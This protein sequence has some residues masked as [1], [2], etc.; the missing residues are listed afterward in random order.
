MA[1]AVSTWFKGLSEGWRTFT[2]L[3]GF[4]V[5]V[6][7]TAVAIDHFKTKVSDASSVLKYLQKQDTVQTKRFNVINLHLK[8]ISDSLRVEYQ[9]QGVFQE[10]YSKFV[11]SKTGS[12]QEWMKYMNGMQVT[13]VQDYYIPNKSY[14]QVKSSFKMKIIPLKNDTIKK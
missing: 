14:E 1:N 8:H 4:V 7:T 11:S 10:N 6:A 12:V 2:I 13:V 9:N 5:A 3:S